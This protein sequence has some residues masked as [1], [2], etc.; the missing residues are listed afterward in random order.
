MAFFK[1]RSDP[2][3]ER[4]RTLKTEIADLE[5]QI[6]QLRSK[7]ETEPRLRSTVIPNGQETAVASE[8]A[9][10]SLDPVF[11]PV[12]RRTLEAPIE[13][14]DP[15]ELYNDLGVRKFDL[16]AAWRRLQ[17]QFRGPTANNPKLVS[18]LAAGSINGLRPLRY[19]KRIARRRV[20]MLFVMLFL[21]IW[22]IT[23]AFVRHNG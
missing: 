6:R 5:A 22:G 20:M 1:K 10:R 19:E 8:A 2:I 11:E 3:S 13:A 18:Y 9:S 7:A 17:N 23:A 16:A 14:A 12:G 15:A 21:L 4:A